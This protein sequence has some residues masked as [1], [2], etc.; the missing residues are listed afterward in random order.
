MFI[1]VPFQGPN[2]KKIR[3]YQTDKQAWILQYS[4]IIAIYVSEIPTLRR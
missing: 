3:P 1:L 2:I 4:Y